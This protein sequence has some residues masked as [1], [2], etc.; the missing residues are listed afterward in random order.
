M[1]KSLKLAVAVI[2]A[3]G[4]DMYKQWHPSTNLPKI[5]DDFD[6]TND[7]QFESYTA[8]VAAFLD[9]CLVDRDKTKNGSKQDISTVQKFGKGIKNIALHIAP[10]VKLGINLGKD[11]VN[12]PFHQRRSHRRLPR[13]LVSSAVGWSF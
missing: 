12:A 4:A 2:K 5:E 11:N 10:L 9:S 8:K 7:E 6:P 3:V 1:K 13:L